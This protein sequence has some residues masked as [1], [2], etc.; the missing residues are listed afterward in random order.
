MYDNYVS[1]NVGIHSTSSICGSCCRMCVS[2]ARIGK[3]Y[4]ANST[5]RRCI[6]PNKIMEK[7]IK[8]LRPI[9]LGL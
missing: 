5:G 1:G 2:N 6:S 7:Q 3:C 9:N 8:N 4:N